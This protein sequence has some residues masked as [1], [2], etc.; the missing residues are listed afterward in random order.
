MSYRGRSVFP[1][2]RNLL[3]VIVEHPTNVWARAL[4]KTYGGQ[5]GTRTPTPKRQLLRLLC[6]PIPP[7]AHGH[8]SFPAGGLPTPIDCGLLSLDAALG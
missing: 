3:S 1:E 6:L 4:I 2:S 7:L 8:G 5:E